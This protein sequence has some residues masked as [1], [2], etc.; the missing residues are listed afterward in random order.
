MARK[1]DRRGP[2]HVLLSRDHR[3]KLRALATERGWTEAQMLR[4][5][6]DNA[7]APV[8]PS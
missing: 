1:V 6:L 2:F 5:I 8:V 4:H 3:R 7:P